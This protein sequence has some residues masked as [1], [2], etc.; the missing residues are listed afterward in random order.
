ALIHQRHDLA[1]DDDRVVDGIGLVE[2]GMTRVSTGT[3]IALVLRIGRPVLRRHRGEAL[4]VR[5]IFDDTE[6]A[7]IR[8]R[9]QA[10]RMIG[11]VL[12]AAI[13]GWRTVRLPE[14]DDRGA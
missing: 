14:L 1:F 7:A 9:R 2:A 6:D 4:L 10:E 3:L 11:R 13:V 5:R 12:V 8:R